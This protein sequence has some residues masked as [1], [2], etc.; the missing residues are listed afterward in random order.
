[1][2]WHNRLATYDWRILVKL[3][4]IFVL[5]GDRLRRNRGSEILKQKTQQFYDV[6]SILKFPSAKFI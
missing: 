4:K 5:H 6:S 3:G 2:I 1:M